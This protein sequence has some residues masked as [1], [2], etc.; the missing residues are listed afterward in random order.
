MPAYQQTYNPFAVDDH[1]FEIN[2]ECND[3]LNYTILPDG[4]KHSK[5]S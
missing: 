4:G 3:N 1:R 5:L 2:D